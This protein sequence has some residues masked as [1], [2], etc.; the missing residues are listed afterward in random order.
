MNDAAMTAAL[1]E[2]KNG[3]YREAERMYRTILEQ[4]PRHPGAL[5]LLGVLA[6]EAGQLETAMQLI[7]EAIKIQPSVASFHNNL[8]NVLEKANCHE[9]AQACYQQ[10]IT[11][12]PQYADAHYNLGLS[13]YLQGN[14]HG[15][16]E[17]FRRAIESNPQL[18]AAWNNLGVAL[19]DLKLYPQAS[20]CLQTATKI[21]PDYA[22]AHLNLGNALQKMGKNT[23]AAASTHQALKL[24][25]ENEKAW[26]TLGVIFDALDDPGA[27]DCFRLALKYNPSYPEAMSNLGRMLSFTN[28]KEEGFALLRKAIEIRPNYSDAMWNLA[29]GLLL[30]GQYEEGWQKHEWRWKIDSF[31]SPKRNFP[32]PQWQGEEIRG[33]RLLLHSEQGFGDTIQFSRFLPMVAASGAHIFLEVREPLRRLMIG[34]PGITEIFL[35]GDKL[36]DFDL[37]CPLMSLPFVFGTKLDTIPPPIKFPA[38]AGVSTAIDGSQALPLRIGLVWAGNPTHG[39]DRRRSMSLQ[40]LLPLKDIPHVSFFCV[41]KGPATA[42]IAELAPEFQVI[43][44]CSDA[45]DFVDTAMKIESLDL[46]ISVDTAVAHLAATL[47]KPV[48]LLL[49]HTPDWRW[50]YDR[51]D[52]PWYSSIRIFRQTAAGNWSDVVESVAR[53]LTLLVQKNIKEINEPSL[54]LSPA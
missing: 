5:H 24:K 25:P 28:Q 4:N 53:E 6:H 17:S 29:L 22:E 26:N 21:S 15:S 46:V 54:S 52:S 44:L 36:P 27:V 51:E 38:L 33:K 12:H 11:L 7:R 10:A 42:Q 14:R 37:H 40:S 18:P 9:E 39:L 19:L 35:Y 3:N 47:G 34:I 45:T 31:P 49:P 1:Q 2:H 50:L 23:E 8:G 32:Q 16:I 30:H 20:A 13:Y 48:W 43:D 41:F